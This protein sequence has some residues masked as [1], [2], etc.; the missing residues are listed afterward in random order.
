MY[1]TGKTRAKGIQLGQCFHSAIGNYFEVS[2]FLKKK[3]QCFLST[4][5]TYFEVACVSEEKHCGFFLPHS[6][7]FVAIPRRN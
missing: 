7:L 4:I 2:R 5:G 3:P 1:E 6:S